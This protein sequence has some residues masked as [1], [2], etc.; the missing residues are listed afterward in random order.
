MICIIDIYVTTQTK[1]FSSHLEGIKASRAAHS[2]TKALQV[3]NKQMEDETPTCIMRSY[4][5]TQKDS[6]HCWAYLEG[7]AFFLVRNCSSYSS[8]FVA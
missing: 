5:P 4:S 7:R 3:Q 6:I 2:I 1:L 8:L